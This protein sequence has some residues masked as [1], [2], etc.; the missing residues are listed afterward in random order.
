[1]TQL[2]IPA[3]N[4]CHRVPSFSANVLVP[5]VARFLDLLLH[6]NHTAYKHPLYFSQIF[7]FLRSKRAAG[8]REHI[9]YDYF[10]RNVLD[11][12]FLIGVGFYCFKTDDI[13]N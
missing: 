2:R 12:D 7:M 8:F 4:C 13:H 9:S 5:D 11:T 1:M 6:K 10:L 3:E